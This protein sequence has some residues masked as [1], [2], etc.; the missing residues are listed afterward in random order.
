MKRIKFII[1]GVIM[2]TFM[3]TLLGCNAIDNSVIAPIK[4]T[5][6]EK[7]GKSFTVAAIGDRIDRDTAT[8]Y[9]YADDNPTMRFVVRV[10][11]TGKVVYEDYPYRLMC[12]MMENKIKNTFEKYSIKSEC[13]VMFTPKIRIN[14]STDMT[15]DE[16]FNVN[17]PESASTNIIVL[18]DDNL[19]GENI[20][21]VYTEI[22]NFL[23]DIDF[24]TSLRVL[25]ERDFNT[26][27]EK[28]RNEVEPFD[29]Y[30][31]KSYG[32]ID[33]IKELYIKV[34]DGEM[35]WTASEIDFELGKE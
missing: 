9:V 14:V 20:V 13:F 19:T 6:S 31:V 26:V 33:N 1:V 35:P 8:A 34:E 22:G 32:A 29:L 24:A 28:I 15:F 16:F 10:D 4:S 23:G 27:K 30:T 18:S 12:R 21:N 7:Y 5:L 3:S 17:S 2:A 25:T 11:K